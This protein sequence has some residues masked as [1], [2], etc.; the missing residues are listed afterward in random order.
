LKG[1]DV[2]TTRADTLDFLEPKGYATSLKSHSPTSPSSTTRMHVVANKSI[3]GLS[4]LTGKTVS[5]NLPDGG[6]NIGL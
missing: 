3:R 4:D 2:G 6:S 1:V 5:V